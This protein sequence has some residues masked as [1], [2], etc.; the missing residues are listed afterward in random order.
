MYKQIF[1]KKNQGMFYLNHVNYAYNY[2]AKKV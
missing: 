1:E 2:I